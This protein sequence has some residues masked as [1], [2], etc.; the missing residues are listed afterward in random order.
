VVCIVKVDGEWWRW[1][2]R[3]EVGR[4]PGELVGRLQSEGQGSRRHAAEVD[5]K[6]LRR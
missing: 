5:V 4:S 6:S 3:E 2:S 1:R